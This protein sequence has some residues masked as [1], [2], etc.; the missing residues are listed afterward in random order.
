MSDAEAKDGRYGTGPFQ[1]IDA[2]EFVA[3]LYEDSASGMLAAHIVKYIA[4]AE[5]KG[6]IDSLDKAIDY[7]KR[8]RARL[9][10]RPGTWDRQ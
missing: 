6:G 3:G 2:M 1:A 5:R 10:G 8:L 9:D 7:C 4:R